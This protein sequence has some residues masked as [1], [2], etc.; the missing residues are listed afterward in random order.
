MRSFASLVLL[1]FVAL[2]SATSSVGSR[3][4]VVLDNVEDKEAYSLFFS[5]LVGTEKALPTCCRHIRFAHVRQ[6]G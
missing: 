3:L 1:L 6:P 4:L 2:V 5:D